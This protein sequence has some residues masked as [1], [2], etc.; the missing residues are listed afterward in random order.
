M[1]RVNRAGRG[2]ASQKGISLFGLLFWAVVVGAGALLLAKLVPVFNEYR[3]IQ[4]IV[5]Q[6]ATSGGSSVPEIRASFDRFS[7]T[8]YGIESI[9]AKD[10][11]ITKEDEKVVVRFAYNKEVELISPVFLLIKFQGR[12]K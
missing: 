1:N 2:P 8:Q 4:G 11:E 6:M 12:S 5:N 7:V 9:T 10:L 3:T